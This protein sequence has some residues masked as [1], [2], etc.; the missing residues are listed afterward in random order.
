ME[1]LTA[2]HKATEVNNNETLADKQAV[3]AGESSSCDPTVRTITVTDPE[4]WICVAKLPPDT[5]HQAFQDLLADFGSVREC[6]LQKSNKTGELSRAAQHLGLDSLC[7][8][9]NLDI[10]TLTRPRATS[11]HTTM[12][13]QLNCFFSISVECHGIVSL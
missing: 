7:D 4:E 13:V 3:K 6:F 8:V 10:A 2:S 9:G 11:H 12:K 1:A 5:S